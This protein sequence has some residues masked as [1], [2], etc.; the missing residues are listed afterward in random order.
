METWDTRLGKAH[1][2]L[3]KQM[4]ITQINFNAA[5]EHWD[6]ETGET[7]VVQ[8]L[9]DWIQDLDTRHEPNLP[10]LR[11]TISSIKVKHVTKSYDN[12][13]LDGQAPGNHQLIIGVEK[14]K[15]H[16]VSH[17][18]LYNPLYQEESRIAIRYLVV[19]CLHLNPSCEHHFTAAALDSTNSV[20]YDPDSRAFYDDRNSDGNHQELAR[21]IPA[22]MTPLI[23][24]EEKEE[25]EAVE[26]EEMEEAEGTQASASSVAEPSQEPQAAGSGTDEVANPPPSPAGARN[27]ED[28]AQPD[29]T[30]PQDDPAHS[31]GSPAETEQQLA[32]NT[33]QDSDPADNHAAAAANQEQPE[34]TVNPTDNPAEAA[35][36]KSQPEPS[37]DTSTDTARSEHTTSNPKEA[38]TTP[39]CTEPPDDT[40]PLSQTHNRPIPPLS[41]RP[42]GQTE[43][44]SS[45]TSKPAALH[46]PA[47]PPP[48]Q[49]VASVTPDPKSAQAA[50]GDPDVATTPVRPKPTYA[51]AVQSP[52]PVT[53]SPVIPGPPPATASKPKVA[54]NPAMPPHPSTK[55]PPPAPVQPPPQTPLQEPRKGKQKRSK[56]KDRPEKGQATISRYYGQANQ[57]R[58]LGT[59]SKTSGDR[60]PNQSDTTE[61]SSKGL[62]ETT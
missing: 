37:K 16:E 15:F 4:A 58:H 11:E 36:H 53:R 43:T 18:V 7:S 2:D 50:S 60:P 6:T 27:D 57:Q 48:R 41:N 44:E 3:Y 49:Q 8:A 62:G 33:E 12:T 54:R 59:H 24:Q 13:T 35:D 29:P 32:P 17:L 28:S 47:M 10:S 46:N 30:E 31:N 1:R 39:P 51:A 25:E 38:A 42:S 26:D 45:K 34:P 19:L 61:S 20:F 5:R 55:P 23:P 52:P 56:T 9:P 22:M 21:S 40:K 14:T